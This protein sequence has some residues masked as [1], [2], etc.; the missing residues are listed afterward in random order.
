MPLQTCE[1]NGDPGY[2]YGSNGKCYTYK[3]GDEE[4]RKQAKRKSIIQGTVIAQNTGEKLHLEKADYEDLLDDETLI[5]IDQ[6]DMIKDDNRNMLFGWGY[7]S[8]DIEG[9]QIYDHSGEFI[10]EEDFEDLELATYAYA[11]A[12]R[13]A[14]TQHDCIAKGYLIE[15]MVFTKEKVEAMR[16]S[17]HLKGDVS[18]G[19]WLGFYFPNDDDYNEIKK[20]KHPMFS[21]YG[22]ATKEVIEE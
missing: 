5:K 22:K 19:I 8:K 18:Q 13:E 20:M 7:V 1:L 4:G 10:K 11:L 17:G 14:D 2:R 3:A 6:E 16:K 9:K 15:S 12:F 21:L